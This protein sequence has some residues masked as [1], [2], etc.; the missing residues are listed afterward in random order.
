MAKGNKTRTTA[1]KIVERVQLRHLAIKNCAVS[2]NLLQSEELPSIVETASSAQVSDD[3]T[4]GVIEVEIHLR[5][6]ARYEAVSD[7][8]GPTKLPLFIQA[9]YWLV[10][11]VASFKG[12]DK[13]DLAEFGETTGM[14]DVWPYWR[15]FVQTMTTRT[16]MPPLTLP[17]LG[18][19]S[20]SQTPQSATTAKHTK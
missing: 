6:R 4:I 15:E 13:A 14:N 20:Q 11:S 16:G 10:Y 5:L 7:D 17:L 2:T 1:S 18:S 19:S 3:Q 9:T 12:I 8:E